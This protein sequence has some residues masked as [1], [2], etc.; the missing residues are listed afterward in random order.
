MSRITAQLTRMNCRE[1]ARVV[2]LSDCSL[3]R[4]FHSTIYF[5]AFTLVTGFFT[6]T[7]LSC[8]ASRTCDI[9]PSATTNIPQPGHTAIAQPRQT[10]TSERWRQ[11]IVT[12]QNHRT[13][14]KARHA[15]R[16][17]LVLRS[18]GLS[19]KP[20]PP[21]VHVTLMNTWWT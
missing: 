7:G 8:V 19:N 20:K 3:S 10:R 5:T 15:K 9:G 2:I 1:V 4:H 17:R 18:A 11:P 12:P 13:H 21:V 14:P 16:G 6:R